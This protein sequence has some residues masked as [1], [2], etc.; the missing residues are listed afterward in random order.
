MVIKDIPCW[1]KGGIISI[2]LLLILYIASQ[3]MGPTSDM[4]NIF[5]WIILL[6]SLPVLKLGASS[7]IL[8]PYFFVVGAVIGFIYGRLRSCLVD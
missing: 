7:K 4:G 8:V 3:I 1:L 5:D 6:I 2:L